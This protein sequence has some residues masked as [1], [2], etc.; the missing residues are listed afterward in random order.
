MKNKPF[1]QYLPVFCLA[2]AALFFT[3]LPL[4]AGDKPRLAVMNL[5]A[6]GVSK[7]FAASVSDLLMSELS[8]VGEFEV[9]E[10]QQMDKIMKEQTLQQSG[11]LSD[12]GIVEVGKLLAA[13]KTIVGSVASFDFGKVVTIR[14]IN[15]ETGAV[16]V[17]DKQIASSESKILEVTRTLAY[18]L[19]AYIAGKP[20]KAN[21]KMY[22][23]PTAAGF[24]PIRVLSSYDQTVEISAGSED[25][26][27]KGDL[28]V[29]YMIDKMSGKE[30]IKETVRVTKLMS[31]NAIC[32]I[33][34]AIKEE[35][36]IVAGD[37]VRLKPGK[38]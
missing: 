9:V 4:Q 34:P 20:I 1:S 12:S 30:R 26:I 25:G 18:N 11:V 13:K 10:R 6:R 23:P 17:S 2:A 32:Q 31:N 8:S 29:V 38:K 28:Y 3:T 35:E 16:E 7:D 19:G 33:I 37:L 21:G 15:V 22:T 14:L 24:S 27:K 36:Y 5:E